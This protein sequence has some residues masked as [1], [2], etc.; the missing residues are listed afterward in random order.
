[1][2][3]P[4]HH[5]YAQDNGV[6][7]D[8]SGPGNINVYQ[9]SSV[10]AVTSLLNP[11]LLKIVETHTP[12]EELVDDDVEYPGVEAKIEYNHVS[13][14]SDEIRENSGYMEL[15]E[16]LIASIDDE[17]PGAQKKFL[18]AISQKYKEVKK[19][20]FLSCANK[21]QSIDQK[22]DVIRLNSDAIIK[23]VSDR[24]VDVS[25]RFQGVPV[26]LVESAK[27]LIVCYGFINCKILEPIK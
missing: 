6:A 21:P 15:I 17:E 24:I 27:Q 22:L 7:I 1:M 20:L 14:F 12:Y 18:Y 9:G 2:F 19:E 16:G 4:R 8:N 3:T 10:A 5:T 13:V 25:G 23:L 11:L 26:E